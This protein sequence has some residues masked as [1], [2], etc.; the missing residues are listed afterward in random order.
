MQLKVFFGGTFDPIHNGHLALAFAAQK[1]FHSEIIFLP[2]ADP[3]H[4]PPTSANAKHRIRMVE[5]AIA[6]HLGFRCDARELN[7]HS[8]SYSVET[9][10]SLRAE[11][12]Q[13]VSIIWLMGMD[14][15]LGLPTWW[16]WQELFDLCHF[17]IVQRPNQDLADMPPDLHHATQHRWVENAEA[18]SESSAGKLFLLPMALRV[19][20]A[21][22]IRH[23]LQNKLPSQVEVPQSVAEYIQT[24]KLYASGV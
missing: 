12:G 2:S 1:A 19:E 11:L 9:L 8:K 6:N 14:S 20:S 17:A 18:L 3:P 21:T 13:E 22:G 4:R 5:L 15:F 16:H 10:Q 7:R 23:S 24:H